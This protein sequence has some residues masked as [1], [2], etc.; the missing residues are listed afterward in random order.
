MW[1]SLQRKKRG[2]AGACTALMKLEQEVAGFGARGMGHATKARLAHQ[3]APLWRSAT[4]W[5]LVEV[6]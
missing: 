3:A 2:S 1:S 4:A 5:Q 6:S